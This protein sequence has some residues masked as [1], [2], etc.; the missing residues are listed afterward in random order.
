MLKYAYSNE[1]YSI[2]EYEDPSIF[3]KYDEIL[4]LRLSILR[5]YAS[6]VKSRKEDI[7]IKARANN[8]FYC[9]CP[10]HLAM[11][12]PLR[13]SEKEGIFCCYGCDISGTIVSLIAKSYG[14][15]KEH[16]IEILHKYINQRTDGLNE[17]DLNI[18][19]EAF[20]YYH[21]PDVE[22]YIEESTRKTKLLDERINRYIKDKNHS[23][24]DEGKVANR[25]CCSKKY[26]KKF[27]P[28][29]IPKSRDEGF[30]F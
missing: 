10:Y 18:L 16:C 14:I 22:K 26:I 19:K 24:E 7:K 12:L 8:N 3:D 27:I 5:V 6:I 2:D 21:S 15:S 30:P 17:K 20:Q 25:L 28:K 23:L 9:K 29:S 13:I 4:N 11:D 1:D